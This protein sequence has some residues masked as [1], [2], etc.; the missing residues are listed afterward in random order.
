MAEHGWTT[1]DLLDPRR[2]DMARRLVDEV[3]LDPEHPFF[4]SPAQAWG[5]VARQLSLR[6]ADLV[7]P[8]VRELLPEHRV[9]LAGLTTKGARRGA[10]IPYHQDWTYTDERRS[11]VVFLWCPL[12][13]TDPG[14]GGLAVVPGSHR[15]SAN[16][17]PS[18]AAEPA[19]QFQA[20]LH[21]RSVPVT[22]AAGTAVAFDPGVFHGSAPNESSDPRPAFTVAL[23]PRGEGLVHFHQADGGPLEGYCVDDE[24]FTI[25]PYRSR[26]EGYA[27]CEPWA[28]ALEVEDLRSA[29]FAGSVR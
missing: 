11:R 2:L 4:A 27:R 24:F 6:L 21:A 1:T 16:I 14:N 13:D 8:V 25:N 15:W 18:R 17:R 20:E 26:P 3:E 28:P 7:E 19:E 22:L 5:S 10:C 12:V 29:L 9:F 23:V